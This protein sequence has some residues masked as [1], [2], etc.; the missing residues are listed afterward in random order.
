MKMNLPP[1]CS[2]LG[3]AAAF[4]IFSKAPLPAQE[5]NGSGPD[6]ETLKKLAQSGNADAE[7]ELGIRYLGGEGLEKDEKQAAEWLQKSAD[8]H[9]L[10]AMNAIGTLHEEGVGMPKDEKK[11]FEWY[12]KAAKYGFP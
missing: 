9:N 1:K 12:E 8:E 7:F 5:G 2:W 6:V 3:V 11:A 4:A 10:A